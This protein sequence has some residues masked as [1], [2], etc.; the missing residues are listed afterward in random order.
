L[1]ILILSPLHRALRG[2]FLGSLTLLTISGS[3]HAQLYVAQEGNTTIGK[4]KSSTGATIDNSFI[5]VGLNGPAGL[6]LSGETLYVANSGNSTIGKYSA[7][8]GDPININLI[9]AGLTTPKAIAI[10]DQKTFFVANFN[11]NQ[12]VGKYKTENGDPINANFIAASE[13]GNPSALAI[14]ADG[15]TLFLAHWQQS[16]N[17]YNNFGFG[18]V[19]TYET[20]SG[21][22][23]K[24]NFILQ[25]SFPIALAMSADGK[26]L[27][28]ANEGAGPG[29]MGTGSVGAYDA[30]TGKAISAGL[31]TGLNNPMGIAALGETLF[32]AVSPGG[33]GS[34]ATYS[35]AN[36]ALKNGSFITSLI[37]PYGIAVV[38]KE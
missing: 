34:I 32:V 8:T 24:A 15:Q 25:L 36:G 38:Q 2:F 19:S 16:S 28:V 37:S 9:S 30:E 21:K 13:L 29:A 18:S 35:A 31:I 5:M 17:K 4:Y 7:K 6:A 14:S 27:F 26:T 3:V 1:K 22:V 23:I 10:L 12:T 33:I 11:G 20:K